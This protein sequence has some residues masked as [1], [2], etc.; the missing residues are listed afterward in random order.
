M[1][2]SRALQQ[3]RGLKERLEE[4]HGAVVA[5]TNQKAEL[6]DQLEDTKRVIQSQ[7][8]AQ[9]EIQAMREAVKEREMMIG[10]LRNQVRHL[11]QEATRSRSPDL[12]QGVEIR[13]QEVE[14]KSQ[15]Q[16]GIRSQQQEQL[17]QELEQ[18]RETIRSLGSCNS[19]LRSQMEVLAARTRDCSESPRAGSSSSSSE[20][21]AEMVGKTSTC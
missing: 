21:S 15:Q 7:E 5:L 9:G 13:S 14:I 19:E 2:A 6:L 18:A 16:T 20:G 8:G 17:E 1:A 12:R 10:N 11:E 3:N 4:L